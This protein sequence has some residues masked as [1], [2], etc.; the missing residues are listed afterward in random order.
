MKYVPRTFYQKL[1]SALQKAPGFVG[2]SC[3]RKLHR[4][5]MGFARADFDAVVADLT[6]DD[7]CIDLGANYGLFTKI[8]AQSGATVHAFEPD[9]DTFT[10]LEENCGSLPN[11]VLH[12]AGVSDEDGTFT[13]TRMLPRKGQGHSDYSQG[14]S[15]TFDGKKMNFDDQVD[16]KIIDLLAFMENLPKRVKLVKMDIEGAEW[17]ILDA[18]YQRNA[19]GLFEYMFVETHER[20]DYAMLPKFREL[21]AKALSHQEPVINLYWI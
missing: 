15:I 6:P 20:V 7:I 19:L 10:I 17:K 1:L 4:S 9:P 3:H 12:Q 2:R 14:S 11:V 21:R 5:Y 16:V 13:L 8:M 18:V